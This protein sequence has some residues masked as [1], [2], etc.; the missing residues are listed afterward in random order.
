[1]FGKERN[2]M[3][4]GTLVYNANLVVVHTAAVEQY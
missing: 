1:M 2:L 3:K 4:I